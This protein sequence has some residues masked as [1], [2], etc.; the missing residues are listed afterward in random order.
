MKTRSFRISPEGSR[1]RYS[2]GHFSKPRPYGQKGNKQKR[3]LK[4][5]GPP[6]PQSETIPTPAPC[7]RLAHASCPRLMWTSSSMRQTFGIRIGLHVPAPI[8]LVRKLWTEF[9]LLP[10]F[11]RGPFGSP[12]HECCVWLVN[13]GGVRVPWT[14]ERVVSSSANFIVWKNSDHREIPNEGSVCFRTIRPHTCHVTVDVR[15]QFSPRVTCQNSLGSLARELEQ[16]M[17]HFLSVVEMERAV[18]SGN[19]IILLS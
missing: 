2:T 3:S 6:S 10:H 19:Q 1:R 11:M 16:M 17:H 8:H 9:H 4:R 7:N 18:P 15:F 12:R 13:L 14:A 5:A